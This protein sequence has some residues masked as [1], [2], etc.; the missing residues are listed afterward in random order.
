[1]LPTHQ[2]E[3]PKKTYPV[4]CAMH[5]QILI[6]QQLDHFVAQGLKN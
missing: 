1:M 5:E 2:L 6:S 3:S 4:L